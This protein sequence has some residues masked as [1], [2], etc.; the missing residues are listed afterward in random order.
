MT[1]TTDS[2]TA[3]GLRD[4]LI[5]ENTPVELARLV[6]QAARTI[7]R[8]DYIHRMLDDADPDK[9]EWFRLKVP[10]GY[11]EQPELIIVATNLIAEERQQATLLR[12]L[13]AEI[14][15]QRKDHGL[16]GDQIADDFDP[17][18]DL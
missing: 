10:R 16:I 12:Q 6:E 2:M 8:L 5:E 9:P 3:Q 17:T 13:M 11:Q 4:A 1:I 14:H 18:E 7:A 15:R